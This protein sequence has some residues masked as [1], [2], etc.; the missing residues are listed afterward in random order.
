M[1][2]KQLSSFLLELVHL[3]VWVS[4]VPSL[5]SCRFYVIFVDDCSCFT[6]QVP[7]LSKSDVYPYFLKFKLLV[8]KQFNTAIKQCQCDNSGEYTSNQFKQYLSQHGIFHRVTSPHTSQQNDIA[9]MKHRHIVELGHTLL[10]QS[11]LSSKHGSIP[12]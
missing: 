2:I 7:I 5:A 10:A 1:L 8:K 12:F 4:P 9:E 11:G 6:W 3:D